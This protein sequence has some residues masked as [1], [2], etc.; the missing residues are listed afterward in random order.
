MCRD[1]NE[2]VP[3][4]GDQLEG[5]PLTPS[6]EELSSP[7]LQDNSDSIAT[8]SDEEAYLSSEDDGEH[9]DAQDLGATILAEIQRGTYTCLI[10]T[11][12]LDSRSKIW[13]C[14]F[15]SRVFDLSCVKDWAKRGS[16][17]ATNKSWRC[18][19]CN[20][21][22]HRI[23]KT[24]TCWC[25]KVINPQTNNFVPHSC[26]QTCNHKLD[27]CVHGCSLE[28]HP[29][30]HMDKCTALG[31][32][33][34]CNCGSEERQLP[35]VLTPYE[36]GW[37]C[38]TVCND[39][40]PCG[41]HKCSKTCHSGLCGKCE[42]DIE[43]ICYCGKH[44]ATIKCFERSPKKSD[45]SDKTWIGTFQCDEVCNDLF[46]C[47]NHRC[48][49]YCHSKTPSCIQHTCPMS[50]S[51]LSTCP[52]GKSKIEMLLN[53]N[54][55][56]SCLDLIPTCDSICGKTL[57]CGHTCYWKCHEGECAPCYK[58]VDMKCRCK[59]TNY[60][61]ACSLNQSGYVPT[62][63][64][65][66]QA[67]MNCRRHRCLD[68]CCEYEPTAIVRERE[69]QKG[70]RK[71]IISHSYDDSLTIEACHIC[72]KECGKLLSCGS[73]YCQMTCHLGPCSPCLESSSD[74]LVC[75]CGRT[76]VVAPVRC[77]AKLPTC[78][79]QCQRSTSCGH[80]PE[81]H[82]CHE[83]DTPCPRCTQI[84]TRTCQCVKAIEVKNVMCY[85][86]AVSCFKVCGEPLKC[87]VHPCTKTCHAPYKCNESI[88]CKEMMTLYCD[89]K[90][91]SKKMVCAFF[92]DGANEEAKTLKC[93][94]ECEREQRNQMLFE[95][96]QLDKVQNRESM[97]TDDVVAQSI[98]IESL[99][100]PFLL[101]LYKQ[102]KS[103]C[104]SIES[105]F[106]RLINGSLGRQ[107]HHFQPMKS[108][109]RRFIHELAASFK[110]SSESQDP[111]PKRSVFVK[112]LPT[113]KIPQM[114]LQEAIIIAEKK[115]EREKFKKEQQELIKQSV[116]K[117]NELIFNAIAIKDLFFGV[118]RDELESAITP[119]CATEGMFPTIS[120]PTI[121]W[122]SDN[123]FVFYSENFASKSKVM[124]RD[125]NQLTK[126]LAPVLSRNNLAYTCL[127]A[128]IDATATV[129]YEI[130][131][132]VNLTTDSS[133]EDEGLI[134][135]ESDDENGENQIVET[136]VA[137][138][139]TFDW[140]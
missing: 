90:R 7:E 64:H 54:Q 63:K 133:S 88:P 96:F 107:S 10:C 27:G 101:S 19:S 35:C 61:V 94:S 74:D 111:E 95:A 69:R 127:L 113:T 60:S 80:R 102:Q 2:K 87:G 82:N 78:P 25:K 12:E 75:H 11:C 110:L 1:H 123:T 73:H 38:E 5:E 57:Q 22:H 76:V 24:Y 51:I 77:G 44:K 131:K 115:K 97:L 138:E 28:C 23:P 79:Y 16:S 56:D 37:S 52:C 30:A 68:I 99:Y 41:L 72:T 66:C 6:T 105:I 21:T 85:Q 8:E 122:V 100:T 114:G 93:D 46:D 132:P 40:M 39:L 58:T 43:V 139:D 104:D 108:I 45:V 71:N 14:D 65:K 62:C 109:Q 49:E 121:K 116:L 134:S 136:V 91:M 48:K 59:Y 89:C 26:G 3:S 33:L 106:H 92:H 36:E 67:L 126:L 124:E 4:D 47:G 18:P 53:G 32:N 81:I 29:G 128:K 120:N 55:R 125:L 50:P 98:L 15:C 86:E 103:W 135:G 137:E 112:T 70:I 130:K 118:T 34:S 84:V 9:D 42:E 119:L 31:P 20:G 13:S 83:S 17:T 140:Y 129:V 117:D